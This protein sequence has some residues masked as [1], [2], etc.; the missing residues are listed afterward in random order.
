MHS[1]PHFFCSTVSHGQARLTHCATASFLNTLCSLPSLCS[2]SLLPFLP[3]LSSL[4]AL[5][6]LLSLSHLSVLCSAFGYNCGLRPCVLQVR[7]SGRRS[8]V[9]RLSLAPPLTA[10][11]NASTS[12]SI[13]AAA[14][15]ASSSHDLS[16]DSS[17]A[18]ASVASAS[19]CDRVEVLVAD[20]YDAAQRADVLAALGF[21]VAQLATTTATTTTATTSGV[22][23]VDCRTQVRSPNVAES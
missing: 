7:R 19:E 23:V 11:T 20:P 15:T 3:L 13:A 22:R 17:A 5:S 16:D 6:A 12:A 14:D 21:E 9:A 18:S 8:L 1:H 4:H 10:A 2:L